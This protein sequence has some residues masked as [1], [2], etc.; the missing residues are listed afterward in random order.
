MQARFTSADTEQVN[1]IAVLPFGNRGSDPDSEYLS[2]GFSDS[3]IYRLTQLPDLKVS[4]TSS[5]IRYKGQTADVSEIAR[6]LEVDAV[7]SGKLTQRG[8]DLTISVELVDART[9]KLIWAEQYDRKMS[10]LLASSAR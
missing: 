7:M 10:D 5:V 4:P 3:L 8:S 2:D 6:E 9:K 1:S